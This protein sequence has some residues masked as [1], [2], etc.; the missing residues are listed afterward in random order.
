[1]KRY[2]ENLTD[3]R[4]NFSCLNSDQKVKIAHLLTVCLLNGHDCDL[5][6]L[7]EVSSDM[8][9]QLNMSPNISKT[10]VLCT[11]LSLK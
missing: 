6:F 5:I 10:L 4:N 3:L 11:L 8:S 7:L 2:L 9:H 1:M